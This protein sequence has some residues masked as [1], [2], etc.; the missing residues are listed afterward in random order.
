MNKFS[1][2][3]LAIFA[4]VTAQAAT[5]DQ[6]LVRQQW[7]WS[8]DIRV[9]Y[10]ISGIYEIPVDVFVRA[11]DGDTELSVPSEAISGERFSIKADGVGQ[12]FIDPVK[13]FGSTKLGM[14]NFKVKLETELSDG[15]Y[16]E[17]LYKIV[18]LTAQSDMTDV[19]TDVTKADILNGKYGSFVSEY[20]SIIEG[21]S[22]S[23]CLIWT[24]VTNNPAYKTTHM[25][26]RRIAATGES[27]TMGA[28]KGQKGQAWGSS[29]YSS[30]EYPHTVSFTNDFYVAVFPTTVAQHKHI[31]GAS[32]DDTDEANM[33]PVRNIL[34]T[35][36]RGYMVGNGILGWWPDAG[37]WS[38][39]GFVADPN[40]DPHD[41]APN[42]ALGL[43]RA[44]TGLR[45]DL[46]TE[47][48][49]EYACRAGTTTATYAGDLTVNTYTD[50]DPVLAKI[51]WC[52]A[53]TGGGGNFK[54]VGMLAPN[55]WGLYDM[56]GNVL[57]ECLDVSK[58]DMT[59]VGNVTDPAGDTSTNRYNRRMVRGGG[60]A[61]ETN[62]YRFRSA[63]RGTTIDPHVEP[64]ADIGYRLIFDARD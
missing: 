17:V 46:P 18:N 57:E 54:K 63:F 32:V 55:P 8:T 48:R 62:S 27:F 58:T 9:E 25:V 56:L 43:F 64:G 7:P 19:V 38:S 26:F 14:S 60:S 4:A 2:A 31:T 52:G 39:G 50:L 40:G 6:V 49:W 44:K 20:G 36:L 3:V 21:S 28:P 34:W 15:R 24:G 47:A 35:D 41:V 22:V 5:I 10:R 53:N 61:N 59:A 29:N 11:F 1:S 12:L 13:A 51:A 42:K 23:D 45:A 30:Y 33:L 37:V 16:D